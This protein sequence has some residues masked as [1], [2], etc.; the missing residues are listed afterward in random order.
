MAQGLV[1]GVIYEGYKMIL[2]R[3]KFLTGMFGLVAAPA[4][5]RVADLMPI[6]VVK[7]DPIN[8]YYGLDNE[9]FL[10]RL[11]ISYGYGYVKPEWFTLEEARGIYG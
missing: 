1:V 11:D 4:V 10:T 7:A 6:R 3:R 2:P 8:V 9:I 5:I